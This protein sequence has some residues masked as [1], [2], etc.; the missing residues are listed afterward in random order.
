MSGER[1]DPWVLCYAGD[2]AVVDFMGKVMVAAQEEIPAI[3]TAVLEKEPLI[4]FREK[5]PAYLDA[6]DFMP[7]W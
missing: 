1:S 4:H 7:Q 3:V 6:D 5:F 2:S